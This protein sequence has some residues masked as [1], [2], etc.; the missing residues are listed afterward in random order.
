MPG[1]GLKAGS[2]LFYRLDDFS[3]TLSD[4][5]LYAERSR[6]VVFDFYLMVRHSD[7]E[8]F[9]DDS[10]SVLNDIQEAP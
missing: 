1:S 5:F 10:E 3:L 2:D 9:R 8:S 6:S 7:A 4:L